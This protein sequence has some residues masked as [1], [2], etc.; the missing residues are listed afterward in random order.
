MTF[1]C[2]F[3]FLDVGLLTAVLMKGR[4]FWD[5]EPFTR[6]TV[7]DVAEKLTVSTFELVPTGPHGSQKCSIILK[8]EPES[9][10]ETSVVVHNLTRHHVFKAWNFYCAVW[11]SILAVD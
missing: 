8:M 1:L 11:T 9:S 5:I 6:Y 3:L 2:Q 10:K 7:I 4:L